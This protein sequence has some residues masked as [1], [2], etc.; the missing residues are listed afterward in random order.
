MSILLQYTIHIVVYMYI[1]LPLPPLQPAV[2]S[3][4]GADSEARLPGQ[5]ERGPDPD[6]QPPLVRGP[7]DVAGLFDGSLS[8]LQE[9]QVSAL[10]RCLLYSCKCTCIH[11]YIVQCTYNVHCTMM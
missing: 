7:G 8:A 6:S 3:V 10:W 2:V 11:K 5:V 1:L 4:S 9:I